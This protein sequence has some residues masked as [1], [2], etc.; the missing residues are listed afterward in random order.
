MV[1]GF[2]R[3]AQMGRIN[4]HHRGIHALAIS[5]TGKLL[6]SG[7]ARSHNRLT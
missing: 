2:A 3:Y 6:A 1:S 4:A 7:G 5:D